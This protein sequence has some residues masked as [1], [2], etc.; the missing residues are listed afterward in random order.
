M[1]ETIGP[2]LFLN[3]LL[4]PG[5]LRLQ[6]GLLFSFSFFGINH[7]LLGSCNFLVIGFIFVHGCSLFSASLYRLVWRLSSL[8]VRVMLFMMLMSMLRMAL[9]SVLIFLDDSVQIVVV[10]FLFWFLGNFLF[11]IIELFLSIHGL[12]HGLILTNVLEVPRSDFGRV[13]LAQSLDVLVLCAN[14]VV[15]VNS[16]DDC[17]SFSLNPASVSLMDQTIV[18]VSH[19]ELGLIF[20]LCFSLSSL[21][22]FVSFPGVFFLLELLA[23]FPCLA[24]LF[25][26]FFIFPHIL[27]V[28][29]TTELFRWR[30]TLTVHIDSAYRCQL[31]MEDFLT[32]LR[33]VKSIRHLVLLQYL[34]SRQFLLLQLLL[35]HLMLLFLIPLLP[36]LLDL[37]K[38]LLLELLLILGRVIQGFPL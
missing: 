26:F 35:H 27:G 24:E 8:C 33:S 29:I 31:V 18:W 25:L 22:S 4:F 2:H 3:F 15:V 1:L 30:L 5:F 19:G 20:L 21:S 13:V 38:L 23:I 9:L 6:S 12:Y 36:L 17:V 7:G 16:G 11:S 37:L 34:Q 28:S 32:I 10:V 14:L